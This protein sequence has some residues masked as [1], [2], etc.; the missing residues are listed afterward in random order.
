MIVPVKIATPDAEGKVFHVVEA[1]QSFWAIA[2]AYKIT[3]RDLEIWNNIS[4]DCGL[5][6]GQVLFIPGSNTEGYATPTP[7]GMVQISSP[8]RD[9]RIIHTVQ[10]YQTLTTIS[11]AYDVQIQ[12]ILSLNGI[13]LDWPL[14]IGQ[15]LLVDPGNVTPS[16]T[17]RPLSPIEKLTPASDG[18]F[19]HVV[20][21]GE[22]LSWIAGLYEVDLADLMVWNGLSGS[23]IIQ[24][25]QK[26]LLQVTPPATE[27]PTPGPATPT[28]SS[29]MAQPTSTSTRAP[30]QPASAP[31]ASVGS[32]P[33]NQAAPVVWFV[34]I[35][36]AAGGLFLAVY[37]SRRR[38]SWAGGRQE[39]NTQ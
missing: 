24:P 17:Q 36:L 10:A 19:Y 39:K 37:I 21:S 2:V 5:Q 6:I 23:S 1:G 38:S 4:R 3:I 26:L 15:K 32:P 13:Q 9:G 7:V 33:E 20:Q 25:G 27:T 30:T 14:Q 34:S 12:T 22:T 16:P 29:T 8:D 31:A 35:G 28:A 11:Q 18:K